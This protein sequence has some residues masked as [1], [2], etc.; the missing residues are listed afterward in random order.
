M[1]STADCQSKQS[2]PTGRHDIIY[3]DCQSKQWQPTG[4]QKSSNSVSAQSLHERIFMTISWGLK[5]LIRLFMEPFLL[6][7]V[8]DSYACE[9]SQC[10]IWNEILWFQCC[11]RSSCS[12]WN[13]SWV[14]AWE[15]G[16]L[17]DYRTQVHLS[18]LGIPLHNRKGGGGEVRLVWRYKVSPY[19]DCTATEKPRTK[20][21]PS[22]SAITKSSH[23][24]FML[25]IAL[26][27]LSASVHET[28]LDF[29][30]IPALT[31]PCRY[32]SQV[33]LVSSFRGFDRTPQPPLGTSLGTLKPQ[34]LRLLNDL[35]MYWGRNWQS[36]STV[37]P[38][39]WL[40]IRKPSQSATL[41]HWIHVDWM[42]FTHM[43]EFR[44]I[45]V[46]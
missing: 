4:R 27:L 8:H 30:L 23:S 2:W 20:L 34:N 45:L 41:A 6:P 39:L 13:K 11:G 42:H 1:S 19:G 7:R 36:P 31:W 26:A 43:E 9:G 44:M 25:C 21:W 14:G 16:Y 17:T 3:C 5:G 22:F 28:T 38:R 15:C 40:L 29:L 35:V 32:S 10:V 18:N 12:T 24:T 37:Y 33:I 46:R